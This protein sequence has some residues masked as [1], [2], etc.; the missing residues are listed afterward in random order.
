MLF[1]RANP[2]PV[3]SCIKKS[4]A[5]SD[6]LLGFKISLGHRQTPS[7]FFTAAN[8]LIAFSKSS[9]ECAA[10]IWVRMRALPCGT[11]G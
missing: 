3:Q 1:R 11:T 10:E 5:K 6:G 8:A 9:R 2:W 4:S 7:S